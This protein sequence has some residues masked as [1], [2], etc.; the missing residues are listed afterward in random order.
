[1]FP[2]L[3]EFQTILRDNIVHVVWLFTTCRNFFLLKFVQSNMILICLI[4]WSSRSRSSR[5]WSAWSADQDLEAN[6]K[7]N[8]N[9]LT[10]G[11]IQI[12]YVIILPTI[13]TIADYFTE[14][15]NWAVIPCI[16]SRWTADSSCPDYTLQDSC[17]NPLQS[18]TNISYI[19][20][21]YISFVHI[22]DNVYKLFVHIYVY[23]L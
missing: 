14:R 10:D 15:Y 9:Y 20:N 18:T 2:V 1:V 8:F 19:S 16:H 5:S 13:Y 7:V 3:H 22:L 23:K 12:Q 11:S 17:S 21:E 6:G 4:C